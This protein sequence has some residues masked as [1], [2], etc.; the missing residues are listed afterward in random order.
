MALYLLQDIKTNF[1][2]DVEIDSKGDL[3]LANALETTRAAVN[4]SLR[5]DLGEYQPNPRI[6]CNLGSYIGDINSRETHQDMESSINLGL[7]RRVVEP[8][9]VEVDV[10]PFSLTEALC[11]IKIKGNYLISGEVTEVMESRQSYT[12]PFIAGQIDPLDL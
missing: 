12:F 8:Q 2:G 10:V 4:F 9:D 3:K 1:E 5:T 11:S 6:G 7:K